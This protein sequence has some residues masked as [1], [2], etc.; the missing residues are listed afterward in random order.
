MSLCIFDL[1]GTLLNTLPT[2]AHYGNCALVKFGFPEIKEER[3]KTLVGDG[4]DVLIHRMLAEFNSG[5]D[6]NFEKVRAAYDSLYEADYM[7]LA[8]P[9]SHIKEMLG[10]LKERGVK[11]AVLSNKPDNVARPIVQSVFGD[12]FSEIWGKRDDFPTKPDPTAA[13]EICRIMNEDASDTVFIGDTSVDIITGK[14]AGFYTIGVE[15]GF[16]DRKEL[17]DAGADFI[18]KSALDIVDAVFDRI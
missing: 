6:E 17:E 8:K 2:I 7:Y 16:R 4:R 18:A 10:G 1:D 12:I 11:L 5:T 15:W 3:Y 9:Y 14:N 13:L